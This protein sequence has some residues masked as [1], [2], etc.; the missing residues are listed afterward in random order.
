MHIMNCRI[1]FIKRLFYV[2]WSLIFILGPGLREVSAQENRPVGTWKDYFPYGV[3]LEVIAGLDEDGASIAFARTEY[4]VFKVESSTN[5]TTRISQIQGLSQSNPTAMSWYGPTEVLIVGYADGNI[6]L[7][8][9]GGTYNMPDIITSSLIGDKGIRKILVFDDGAYLACGFGVVV[10]DLEKF[11]VRDTWFVTG[12]QDLREVLDVCLV[13]FRSF[14]A[15]FGRCS[16]FFG[17][18]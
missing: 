6:D 16:V 18:C 1:N 11:E 2:G 8:S 5:L 15:L 14:L 10:L 9:N 13:V 3:V 12:S 4:A 17:L 7:V